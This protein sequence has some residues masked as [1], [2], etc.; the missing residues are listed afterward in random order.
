LGGVRREL[1]VATGG[2]RE[3]E[4][5]QGSILAQREAGRLA[6]L[7]LLRLLRRVL[8][9]LSQVQGNVHA[10]QAV[11]GEGLQGSRGRGASHQQGHQQGFEEVEEKG[12]VELGMCRSESRAKMVARKRAERS[13]KKRRR[14]AG[15]DTYAR[16]GP[17]PSYCPHL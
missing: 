16:Q 9:S 1:E 14:G 7:A 5:E 8:S 12:G 13:Q 17:L 15:P 4:M 6:H 3:C 10:E 2:W 11:G